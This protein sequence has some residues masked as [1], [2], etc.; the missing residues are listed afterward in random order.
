MF[1]RRKKDQA[2]KE[3]TLVTKMLSG[4]LFVQKKWAAFMQ[5]REG[6]WTTRQKKIYLGVFCTVSLASIT[7]ILVDTFTGSSRPTGIVIE[8]SPMV[9]VPQQDFETRLSSE[10]TINIK[11]FRKLIDSLSKSP[12]GTKTLNDYFQN[13]PGMLDSFLMLENLIEQR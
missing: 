9:F 5:R 12:E 8:Q 1:R 2:T 4:I 7:Y 3:F 13:R 11:S 6:R 10:D